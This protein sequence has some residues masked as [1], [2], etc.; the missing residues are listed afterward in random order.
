ML[1]MDVVNM[2]VERRE[3]EE[4]PVE[5]QAF[6]TISVDRLQAEDPSLRGSDVSADLGRL[7]EDRPLRDVAIKRVVTDGE[8]GVLR[9]DMKSG[10]GPETKTAGFRLDMATDCVDDM[11]DGC[12]SETASVI[13][14]FG[15]SEWHVGLNFSIG[16]ASAESG[17]KKPVHEHLKEEH[18]TVIYMY[19]QAGNIQQEFD[20]AVK[21]GKRDYNTHR[22]KFHYFYFYLTDAVQVLH[23]NQT[24]CRR[25][26]YGTR[27]HFERNVINANMRF[28]A[29]TWAASSKQSSDLKANVSCFE[30]YSCF[31]ADITYYSATNQA[32]QVLIPPYE[33]FK[34]TDV[35]TD[36]PWCTV[37]YKLHS[38]NLL[39]NKVV[40]SKTSFQNV[41]GRSSGKNKIGSIKPGLENMGNLSAEDKNLT[42]ECGLCL[43][44]PVY[45]VTL[46]LY[47]LVSLPANARVL[48]LMVSSPAFWTSRMEVCA[49]HLVLAEM[50]FGFL[51]PPF[52]TL[53][54]FVDARAADVMLKLINLIFTARIE[55]QNCVCFERYVAVV[56]PALYCRA[57]KQPSPGEGEQKGPNLVKK[58][59]FK[60]VLLQ[61]AQEERLSRI[62]QLIA[63]Y[64][65]LHD[66]QSSLTEQL[67]ELQLPS[68][69][70]R[71]G[72]SSRSPYGPAL[73]APS[74]YQPKQP[75][76]LLA[77]MPRVLS[78]PRPF[79][80]APWQPPTFLSDEPCDLSEPRLFTTLPWQPPA[81]LSRTPRDLSE[82]R[83]FSTVPRQ[84]PPAPAAASVPQAP[85]VPAAASV[86]QSLP[87]PAA[88]SA[89]LQPW[90]I[91][92]APS[93]CRTVPVPRAPSPCRT[94]PVP[95]AP[96]PCR[97]VP[98][99]RAPSPCR[100]VP[101]PPAPSPCRPAPVPPALSKSRPAPVPRAPSLP[102]PALVP[103]LPI[104]SPS[105]P[106][107][108]PCVPQPSRSFPM[109]HTRLSRR[110]SPLSRFRFPVFH[111]NLVRLHF[112]VSRR[113]LPLPRFR[114]P[115]SRRHLVLLQFAVSCHHLSRLQTPA[116]PVPGTPATQS[117]T[118]PRPPES[119]SPDGRP[120]A[121]PPDCFC[122]A[123]C[124]SACSPPPTLVEP[125][126][127]LVSVP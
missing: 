1:A 113:S 74:G 119:P 23:H 124:P 97:T 44:S 68:E 120:P 76:T 29:F 24:S 41:T 84:P 90:P 92:P 116:P 4:S 78:E 87:V 85:P 18:A 72:C 58:R 109:S 62:E 125:L 75:S 114:F 106:V 91:R 61:Q 94:V 102:P 88:A 100:T 79:S 67:R 126:G 14:G 69:P 17:A 55:F 54:H 33:V 53:R 82:P 110:R 111:R 95:R 63:G 104:P 50:L 26:F 83:L 57:L 42:H 56:H 70:V 71:A 66:Q 47:V 117:C 123:L 112:P 121:H 49:F 34:I 13:D 108:V 22:F 27:K 39:L 86:P 35:V 122:H 96:S 25:T 77:G 8:Q 38:T 80:T 105:R 10:K 65:E 73:P 12:K 28:G 115:V 9:Q 30:I 32:G 3:P 40:T 118:P 6:W 37:V 98:V 16:W 52:L 46:L 2:T 43:H 51:G 19:T 107:V 101:V 64:K 89:V 93:P 103:P 11:Y 127:R 31:G 36:D 21:T 48:W 45:D 81:F 99:P 15:V 7:P 20:Q 59:A 5:E 60:I